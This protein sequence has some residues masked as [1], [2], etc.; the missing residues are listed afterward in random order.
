MSIDSLPGFREFYPDA[1]ALRNHIFRVFRKVSRNFAFQE[2]DAPVLEPL[3]LYVEKSGPEI[4]G[5]LFNF[6]DKGGRAVALRPEM[7]PS[8]ARMVGSQAGSIKRPVK[9]FSIGEQYRY[10]R[11]QKGRLRA[12]YQFNADIFGEEG[13]GAD[14]ELIALLAETLRGLGLN[15]E[16][17]HIRLSDRNLWFLFLESRKLL[18]EQISGV[19]GVVDK[20]ERESQEKTLES[21]TKILGSNESAS[22]MLEQITRIKG[23]NSLEAMESFFQELG[24]LDALASRL[25]D[26][27]VLFQYLEAMGVKSFISVDLGIVRGLAYYTGF[28]FEA[29]EVSG[30]SRAL[31]GGGRYDSLVGKLTKGVDMAATGFAIG[32]VTLIDCLE[33]N[34]LLPHYLDSQEIYVIIGS[35]AERSAGLGVVGAF[36]RMGFSVTYS[37]KNQ[38]F[39]KQLKDASQRNARLA[40]IVGSEE[41]ERESVKVRDLNQRDEVEVTLAGLVQKVESFFETGELK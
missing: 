32:D 20:S 24:I 33:T 17:F 3:D 19:L 27:K 6:L 22:E 28:V 37:L 35:D 7:T 26:W 40:I 15:E 11:M 39:K 13:P 5:Q 29:F 34:G 14:A 8:L 25:E 4:V 30:K 16:H 1:C 38:N 9:W 36:R 21:L 31:A 10:E 23:L 12:F 2:Y 41:L 18:P